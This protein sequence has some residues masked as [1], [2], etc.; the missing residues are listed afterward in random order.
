MA[1][2]KLSLIGRRVKS[3]SNGRSKI[4]PFYGMSPSKSKC[5]SLFHIRQFILL[6]LNLELT[7]FIVFRFF[8]YKKLAIVCWQKK[9]FFMVKVRI[10]EIIQTEKL[11]TVHLWSRPKNCRQ[12][13]FPQEKVDAPPH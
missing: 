5:K 6:I 13:S 10:I 4:V 7:Y 12:P 8:C 9:C 11:S 3:P 1:F 2:S